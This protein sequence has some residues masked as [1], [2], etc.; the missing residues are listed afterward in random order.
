MYYIYITHFKLITHHY[1]MSPFSLLGDLKTTC[2][3]F[4]LDTSTFSK[5]DLITYYS[6]KY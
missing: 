2:L 5:S 3:N 4:I 1:M 6:E